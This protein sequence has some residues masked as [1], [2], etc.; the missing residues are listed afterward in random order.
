[1]TYPVEIINLVIAKYYEGNKVASISRYFKINNRTIKGW[2]ILYSDIIHNKQFI[3][4]DIYT[5]RSK[6]LRNSKSVKYQEEVKDFADKNE[7]FSLRDVSNHLKKQH[8]ST[9]KLISI[10]VLS[11]MLKKLNY[12][13]QRIKTH[14]F[15]KDPEQIKA[16]RTIYADSVNLD[17]FMDYISIDETAFCPGDF[18]RYGYGKK[19]KSLQLTLKHHS[20]RTRYSALVAMTKT[21]VK[22]VTIKKGSFNK[23]NY[24][25]FLTVVTKYVPGK[26]I[27]HDNASIH[28]AKIVTEWA[29]KNNINIVNNAPYSPKFNPIEFAF[30]K[31]KTIYRGLSNHDKIIN[32]IAN[33]CMMITTPENAMNYFKHSRKEINNHKTHPL[34]LDN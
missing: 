10:S 23:F 7:G 24:L 19:G 28:R 21:G 30:S 31:I 6:R 27:L 17:S 2:L 1:M 13:K 26:T 33:C 11:R 22:C 18:K 32:I 16:G 4:R 29:S 12:T 5:A 15:A 9:E 20:P 25:R 3:S 34:Q 14:V 8:Q